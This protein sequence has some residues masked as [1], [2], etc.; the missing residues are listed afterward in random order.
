MLSRILILTLLCGLFCKSA[1]SQDSI[2]SVQIP[3][4]LVGQWY[5][6][7]GTDEEIF[8][9]SSDLLRVGKS[10]WKYVELLSEGETLIVVVTNNRRKRAVRCRNLYADYIDIAVGKGRFMLYKKDRTA[11]DIRTLLME[12]LSLNLQG[13]WYGTRDRSKEICNFSD[14]TININR[15]EWQIKYITPATDHLLFSLQNRDSWTSLRLKS[16]GDDYI[17]IKHDNSDPIV[18]KRFLHLADGEIISWSTMPPMLHSKWFGTDDENNAGFKMSKN[19]FDGKPN[20][21]VVKIKDQYMIRSR[22][23]AVHILQLLGPDYISIAPKGEEFRLYKNSRLGSNEVIL[24]KEYLPE[25]L[26]GFWYLRDSMASTPILKMAILPDVLLFQEKSW[27]YDEIKYDGKLW[28]LSVMDSEGV[29]EI[30]TFSIDAKENLRFGNTILHK[31]RHS[32][33]T[34]R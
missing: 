26:K 22:N 14:K 23:G 24:S 17:E 34:M 15:K 32:S 16:I 25:S 28:N 29:K 5:K 3:E 33:L 30:V 21:S 19:S 7:D 6:T 13:V 9:F 12:D 2:A 10:Y 20:P 27:K 11:P 31:R 8:E 4:Q 18:Y 1:L